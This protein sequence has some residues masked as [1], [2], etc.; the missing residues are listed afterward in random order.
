[1]TES[2]SQIEQGTQDLPRQGDQ[3]ELLKQIGSNFTDKFQSFKSLLNINK[4]ATSRV[5]AST[6]LFIGVLAGAH[7]V[8]QNLRGNELPTDGH[9]LSLPENPFA[10]SVALANID[11]TPTPT[12]TLSRTSTPTAPST[13]DARNCAYNFPNYPTP[14]DRVASWLT[15]P[16]GLCVIDAGSSVPTH[17]DS[18][19]NAEVIGM[20]SNED[21]RNYNILFEAGSAHAYRVALDQGFQD[22]YKTDQAAKFM[23]AT[24]WQVIY[25]GDGNT[26][27]QVIAPTPISGWGTLVEPLDDAVKSMS[28]YIND[29]EHITNLLPQGQLQQPELQSRLKW[30][31]TVLPGTLT[32]SGIWT[33]TPTPT[34]TPTF[35]Y[36]LTPTDIATLTRTP[37][38]TVTR[39]KTETA[40]PT[41]TAAGVS[42][43]A[44]KGLSLEL[45]TDGSALLEWTGVTPA[46]TQ[47]LKITNEDSSLISLN[48]GMTRFR[49][50]ITTVWG[51]YSILNPTGQ[52]SD[53]LLMLPGS[54]TGN[55]VENFSIQLNESNVANLKW[56]RPAGHSDG[57]VLINLTGGQN[58]FL[59]G[60]QLN[61]SVPINGLGCYLLG[62]IDN[63]AINGFSTVNCG[64]SGFSTLQSLDNK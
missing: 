30:V 64:V 24:G 61:T 42:S 33:P 44:G 20:Y 35:T 11:I 51:G 12:V 14:T 57:Y 2:P 26:I 38:A 47:L 29:R 25:S 63:S 50:R 28:S 48:Q 43:L 60:D 18:L 52:H 7:I 10:P 53:L 32:P 36:T 15:V 37:T 16:N 6:G 55:S 56:N 19:R 8:D 13:P 41:P 45:D 34:R 22:W 59:P 39:T 62:T 46:G 49:D 5:V 17:Y 4:S 31:K 27:V 54:K 21:G 40:S 1:M 58:V 3:F 23:A 9:T